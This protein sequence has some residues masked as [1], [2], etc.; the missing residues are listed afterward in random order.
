[1]TLPELPSEIVSEIVSYIPVALDHWSRIDCQKP[2]N[3]LR[4]GRATKLDRVLRFF[5]EDDI[6]EWDEQD[7]W[8]RLHRDP[9]PID[10]E[11]LQTS[12]SYHLFETLQSVSNMLL[13]NAGWRVEPFYSHDNYYYASDF[14]WGFRGVQ[15]VYLP[16]M[17]IARVSKREN[18]NVYA[19]L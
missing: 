17:E 4:F 6:S 15:S 19:L 8:R 10:H 16:W 2:V 9:Y 14:R 3:K 13:N 1:M 11:Y 7:D 12:A 18:R 5:F